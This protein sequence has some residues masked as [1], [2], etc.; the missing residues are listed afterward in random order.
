[1]TTLIPKLSKPVI[2][3]KIM[4]AGRNDPDEA[5]EYAAKRMRDCDAAC[6]GVYTKDNPNMLEED[7]KLLEK[8][9]A[10]K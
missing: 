10:K 5:F 2:H 3:Y 7:V 9:L 8:N 6:V 1:M 4:A